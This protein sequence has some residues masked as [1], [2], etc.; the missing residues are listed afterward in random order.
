MTGTASG[1][2]LDRVQRMQV[3]ASSLVA[4][5]KRLRMWCEARAAHDGRST[6]LYKYTNTYIMYQN[7][8]HGPAIPRSTSPVC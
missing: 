2:G 6:T 3:L 5:K 1:S 7:V 8:N 4:R